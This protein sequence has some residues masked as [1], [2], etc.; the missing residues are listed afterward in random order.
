[1]DYCN[2]CGCLSD[3]AFLIELKTF[4]QT[5]NASM[6]Y[7]IPST[8]P[9]VN[10]NSIRLGKKVLLNSLSSDTQNF[11]IEHTARQSY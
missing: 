6:R 2:R 1:M 3:E 5:N 9:H 4:D 11:V 7:A 10:Q 8:L